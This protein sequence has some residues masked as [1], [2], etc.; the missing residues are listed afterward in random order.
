M[1]A[2]SFHS[3]NKEVSGGTSWTAELFTLCP[4]LLAKQKTLLLQLLCVFL[5]PSTPTVLSYSKYVVCLSKYN[6]NTKNIL[7]S[8][9]QT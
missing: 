9:N 1:R 3:S 2:E 5:W 6:T 4:I 7:A 8:E